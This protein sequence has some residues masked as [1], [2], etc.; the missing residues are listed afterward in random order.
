MRSE[1]K[2]SQN[3][4]LQAG[5]FAF[6]ALYAVVI[7]ACIKWA[8]VN[9]R[10]ISPSER[11][12]VLRA[13]AINRVSNAGLLLAWPL[14]FEEVVTVP[15]AET[16]LERRVTL[17]AAPSAT[18]IPVSMPA[19][20]GGGDEEQGE[21]STPSFTESGDA[22]AGAGYLLTGDAGVVSLDITVFYAVR[23]ARD[24]VVQSKHVIPA[25]DRIVSRSAVSVCAAR[26][27]DT[28]LVAR[29][30]LL[31]SDAGMADQRERLRSDLVRTI[32]RAL[33]VLTRD[34]TGLGIEVVRVDVQSKLPIDAVSAFEE[35]L[36]ATQTADQTIAAARTAAAYTAQGG[37]QAADRTLQ[38]AEAQASERLA[39]AQSDTVGIL[40]LEKSLKDHTEPG[41][42]TRIYRER[43]HA[44]I[45][46]AGS[47]TL[48]NPKDDSRLIV[49]G[50]KK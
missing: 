48:V 8:A 18:S 28:I 32:N 42:M 1:D 9:I 47:T 4:W 17:A 13:G 24:Y 2:S 46:K 12:V 29:P 34:G 23:N 5:R 33:E 31:N 30:E 35:V 21:S 22:E 44:V 49:D 45:S 3:P 6:I 40:Q 38:L 36:T 25:L 10:Q 15:S 20:A 11:A 16:I 26:D 43:I 27:L 14:P 41:L 39:K 19:P 7:I 50:A 37:N